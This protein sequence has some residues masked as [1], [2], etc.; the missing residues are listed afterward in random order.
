MSAQWYFLDVDNFYTQT[1]L[2]RHMLGPCYCLVYSSRSSTACSPDHVD[3]VCAWQRTRWS[4]PCRAH[5]WWHMRCQ[6]TYFCHRNHDV[7]IIIDTTI[8]FFLLN[9]LNTKSDIQHTSFKV[10]IFPPHSLLYKYD[11]SKLLLETRN[12]NFVGRKLGGPLVR[13]H[14]TESSPRTPLE[15]TPIVLC[16]LVGN[17]YWPM[18]TGVM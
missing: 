13:I 16:R 15:D 5:T 8:H 14:A 11:T 10:S 3:W 1:R 9:E 17:S 6:R 2:H 4:A 7:I 18:Y 12:L